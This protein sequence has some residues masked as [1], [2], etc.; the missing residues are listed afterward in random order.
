MGK[1]TDKMVNKKFEKKLKEIKLFSE[2]E[3]LPKAKAIDLKNEFPYDLCE[4]MHKLKCFSLMIPEELGGEGFGIYET[5]KIIETLSYASASIALLV[6]CHTTGLLPILQFGTDKQ[7]ERFCKDVVNNKKLFAFALTESKAGSDASSIKSVAKK[8]ENGDEYVVKGIKVFVTNIGVSDF[9]T[10]FAKTEARKGSRG[11]SCFV[12]E[13]D[14]QGLEVTSVEEK[15][16]MR[17]IPCGNMRMKNVKV[18][19]GNLIGNEG[20]GFKIALNTL[21]HSRPF[22][23]AQAVGI[24]RYALKRAIVY[25]ANR[26][27]F[28]KPIAKHQA[29]MF[30]LSKM[31]MNIEAAECLTEKTCKLLDENHPD[32]TKFSAMSKALAT[33]VAMD[34]AIDTMQIFGGYSTNKNGDI[35]RLMRDAKITQ[36]FE[37]S[38]E[39]Q[40]LVIGNHLYKEAGILEENG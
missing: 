25:A 7:K 39:I 4:K 40:N 11:I 29:V 15:T 24:A 1:C 35:E 26:K 6:I 13:K 38:N 16:G 34:T 22:V 10:I 27:Q 3:V 21:N 23:A 2:K 5:A 19:A 30:K 17:G 20:A 37:G 8:F 33:D 32:K 28:G 14:L 9:Y 18:A 36:I 12:L 31:A